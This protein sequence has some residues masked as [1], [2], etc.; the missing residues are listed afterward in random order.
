M[1]SVQEEMNEKK[2]VKI[3]HTKHSEDAYSSMAPDPT[4][5]FVRVPCCPTL[6]LCMSL[7]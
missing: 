4:L 7:G 2:I 1:D 5:A 3:K 6:G